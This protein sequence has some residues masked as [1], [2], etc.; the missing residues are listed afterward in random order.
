MDS[1]NFLS[2]LKNPEQCNES[3]FSQLIESGKK[4]PFT[5][6]LHS[7]IAKKSKEISADDYEN[8]LSKAAIYSLDRKKLFNVI[9]GDFS[10]RKIIEIEK[11]VTELPEESISSNHIINTDKIN[12][13]RNSVNSDNEKD[14]E[15]IPTEDKEETEKVKL[16]KEKKK[17][18]HKKKEKTFEELPNDAK[19]SFTG[20][21]KY[22]SSYKLTIPQELEENYASTVYNAEESVKE[23]N[24][25]NT[26]RNYEIPSP[27]TDW[28]KSYEKET[29]ISISDLA[30]KSIR[31]DEN[32]VTETFAKI[33]ELQKKHLQAIDAYEKL[34][35][36]Y[37]EKSS[38]FALRIS[39]IKKKI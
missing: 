5:A 22:L 9:N 12:D 31:K 37:P 32:N 25:E 19:L 26:E 38:F 21:L 8:Y 35:L 1:K 13:K 33:L 11:P 3:N 16:N 39:E 20:W 29:E 27:P 24:S 10:N 15:I 2:L 36:K 4:Y 6:I 34:S 17:K 14:I 28:K 23:E 7:F 18:K 30:E